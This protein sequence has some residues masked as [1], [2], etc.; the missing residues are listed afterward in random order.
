MLIKTSDNSKISVSLQSSAC[1]FRLSNDKQPFDL[2][3]KPIGST[4]SL[5]GLTYKNISGLIVNNDLL[6]K[7][8]NSFTLSVS[9]LNNI[10]DLHT[11]I[12]T[13]ILNNRLSSKVN[14]NTFSTTINQK[15]D[16]SLV[17]TIVGF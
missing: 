14:T 10:D 13:T 15:A 1:T 5:S 17:N 11:K 4:L 2:S 7:C 9:M 3:F 12:T 6:S 8:V 16:L